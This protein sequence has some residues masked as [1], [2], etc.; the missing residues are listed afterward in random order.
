MTLAKRIL[1][2]SIG[3]V[4][5][6]SAPPVVA[7]DW[8]EFN[9]HLYALTDVTGNWQAAEDEALA[10]GGHLVAVGDSDENDF[11]LNTLAQPDNRWIGLYQIPGS[12]E[13][14]E[15]WVWSNGEPVEYTNWIPGQPNNS[16]NEDWAEMKGGGSSWPGQWND[17]GAERML[18]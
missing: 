4:L 17:Q 5:A 3:A 18:R 16:G 11:L 9:G 6:G 13:P 10:L 2:G 8:F 7:H 15:G 14:G 1:I 12:G